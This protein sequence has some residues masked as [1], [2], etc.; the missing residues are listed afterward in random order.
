[1]K[2]LRKIFMVGFCVAVFVIL[3]IFG[4]A[5]ASQAHALVEKSTFLKTEIKQELDLFLER[6]RTAKSRIDRSAGSTGEKN[7]AEYILN[8]LTHAGLT[9]REDGYFNVGLQEFD[10]VSAAGEF[11]KSQNVSVKL[12][13]AQDNAKT[14]VLAARY[15]NELIPTTGK[16]ANGEEIEVKVAAEGVNASAGAVAMLMALAKYLVSAGIDLGFN[17]EFVFFGAG[18]EDCVGAQNYLRSIV[19]NKADY[20]AIINFNNIAV[21]QFNYVYTT[22]FKTAY[23]E[24]VETALLGDYNFVKFDKASTIVSTE[25]GFYHAGNNK[26]SGVFLTSGI[27]TVSIFSGCNSGI[28]DG[29]REL[30]GT[31]RITGTIADTVSGIE[32]ATKKDITANLCLI[33]ES[34]TNL[35]TADG[36]LN[37]ISAKQ[38][39][40]KTYAFWR[41][42]KMWAFVECVTVVVLFVIYYAIYSSLYKKSKKCMSN[43][44]L[45]AVVMKI[46]SEMDDLPPELKNRIKDK[47]DEDA[48]GGDD[49]FGKK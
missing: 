22:E 35:I 8:N 14:L 41:N 34:V 21:G 46:Q 48:N 6:T 13:S 40:N 49:K 28:Q 10:F 27:N 39:V 25:N 1:M 19:A 20:A 15:D 43:E 18:Y 38:D 2:K 23:G 42:A 37:K 17:V 32:I 3:S 16:A 4:G 12:N 31:E 44:E 7:A 30:S 9:A 29:W 24:F 11:L 45:S 5:P 33:A 36:F 47:I 26:D